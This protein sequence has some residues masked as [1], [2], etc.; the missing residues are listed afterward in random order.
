MRT[1]SARRVLLPLLAALAVFAVYSPLL[2]APF[3]FDDHTVIE[4]DAAIAA[5]AAREDGDGRNVDLWRDLW[6]QPRPLRQ[7][8][9]RIEWRIVGASPALPHAVNVLLHLAVA[10]AGW[11][12]LRR[13]CGVRTGIAALA[14]ALFLLNPVVV[15][16][17]GV[18]SH[19]K[20]TLS[21][22]LL[23]LS[24]AAALR[25]PERF[26]P[27]AAALMLLG[28][29]GK[30]TALVAPGLFA[31]LAF[32]APA[33][34]G[35][36]GKGPRRPYGRGLAVSL[37]LYCAVA[38]AGAALF[39][40]QI[41]EG[42][43]FA[44]FDPG[45]ADARGCHL[46]S[47]SPWGDAVSA[48]LRAFPRDL[49]LLALPFGHSPVPPFELRVPVLSAQTLPAA[50]AIAACA[51]LLALLVR[52]RDPALR[53]ALWT[54]VGLAPY[55][56]PALLRTGATAIL[57]D[58]YLYL[59]SFGFAWLLA[60][61]LLRLP[62]RAAAAGAAAAL[63]VFAGSSFRL[64]GFYRNEADYWELAAR[65]N[66][67][68][69]LAAHNHAWAL[70]KERGDSEGARK[71]FERLM[72]LAPGF[73]AGIASFARMLE[74]S[75]D[76]DS[77][78][79]LLD[80]ALHER[81]DGAYLLRQRALVGLAR[82]EDDATVL[83]FFQ[84]AE[85]LG[86]G[87][88]SFLY[89]YAQLLERIPD[90]PAAADRYERAGA[91]AG[92]GEDPYDARLLRSDPPRRDGCVLVLGDSVPHGTGTGPDGEGLLSLAAALDSL[93]AG[94]GGRPA[95]DVSV[96]GTSVRDVVRQFFVACES[97]SDSGGPPPAVC[98]ILSGHNDAFAGTSAA[99]ILSALAE[100]ALE[101]RREGAVP[102]IVGPIA[103]RDQP[104]RSRAVQEEILSELDRRL[105]A[106]CAAGG[107]SH[108]SAREALGPN[109]PA[110]PSGS[111]YDPKTG[112]HLS[113]QG[114][115]TLARAVLPAVFPDYAERP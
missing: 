69:V 38:A 55:L 77:A 7:L 28:A 14:A 6:R 25:R 31:V 86:I 97:A 22:L 16:S 45:G 71:E 49:M 13:R 63:A 90:W 41:R 94:T 96:P 83:G 70:W 39:W 103:V 78:A 52:R 44:G 5:A 66:P 50:L 60:D 15:E 65:G 100:A 99:N 95:V 106:F 36:G 1:A 87:D 107:I 32:P 33:R 37:A 112:N 35:N 43:A 89:D 85:R 102:V 26:S 3:L 75:G 91:F 110:A 92:P 76:P 8:T 81:P 53:P 2:R 104:G 105:A 64:G 23:L 34:D 82:G 11:L 9:H 57:A 46:P 101:C 88:P 4:G 115:E 67:G 73:D 21:A 74:E 20:E 80:A 40:W 84:R 68:S 48:A 79:R 108:V 12:L 24:L 58:R 51:A 47:G 111:N 113:R 93:R 54:I 17:L 42:M 72:R 29:A 62:R 18:V 10:A 19:R 98:V 27:V 59:A 114:V 30:E 61:L 109:D 56:C